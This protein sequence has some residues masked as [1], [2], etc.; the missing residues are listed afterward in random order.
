MFDSVDFGDNKRLT[1]KEDMT[2]AKQIDL[3]IGCPMVL[4]RNMAAVLAAASARG[5]PLHMMGC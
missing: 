2:A 1:R 4:L 3:K 5:S